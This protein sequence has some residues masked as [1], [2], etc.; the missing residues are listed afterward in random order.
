M[1]SKKSERPDYFP[2]KI[3]DWSAINKKNYD[4]RTPEQRASISKK[5]SIAIKKWHK[6]MSLKKK[7]DLNRKISASQIIRLKITPPR[8]KRDINKKRSEGFKRFDKTL[9]GQE[10]RAYTGYLSKIGVSGWPKRK[11]D[12]FYEKDVPRQ[13]N[14]CGVVTE[15]EMENV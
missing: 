13:K 14:Y 10:K 11:T 4:N 5:T 15:Q 8:H 12:C 1:T 6:E 3:P 7:R 2:R 9:Q